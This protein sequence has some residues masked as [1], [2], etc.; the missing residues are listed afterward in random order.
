MKVTVTTM[1]K[2][3]LLLIG[4][5]WMVS[6]CGSYRVARQAESAVRVEN[7]DAA[8]YYYLEAVAKVEQMPRLEGRQMV[9]VMAPK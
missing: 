5:T 2:T 4:L 9:M 8:V 1:R 6:G 7:W 3:L